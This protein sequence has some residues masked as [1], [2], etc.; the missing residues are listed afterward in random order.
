VQHLLEALAILARSIESGDVP[1]I[2]TPA[3]SRSLASFQGCLPA[4][5]HD[6]ALGLLLVDD[7]ED[8]LER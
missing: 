4:E 2:G 8:V 5:L 7:L 3:A 6:D 1:M